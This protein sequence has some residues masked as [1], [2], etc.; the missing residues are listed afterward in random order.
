MPIVSLQP[1]FR[2]LSSAAA[3]YEE[4]R[5]D[6]LALSFL[7]G[8]RLDRESDDP[9]ETFL[10]AYMTAQRAK[11]SSREP[12]KAASPSIACRS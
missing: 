2:L 4:N 6:L 1:T 11:N 8:S 3:F 7:P 10:K 5:L 12:I 9:S